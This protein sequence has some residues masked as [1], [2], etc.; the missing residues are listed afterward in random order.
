M[1]ERE[2]GWYHI[3]RNDGWCIAEY[4]DGEWYLPLFIYCITDRQVIEIDERRIVRPE[5]E[6][7]V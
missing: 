7:S 4:V 3:K 5:P 6:A 1:I 2:S